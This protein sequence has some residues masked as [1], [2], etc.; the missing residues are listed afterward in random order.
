[1]RKIWHDEAWEEYK[2]WQSKDKK[3]LK[4]IN[5]LIESIDRNGYSSIG[6]PEA[7]RGNQAGFYSIRIDKKNRLIFRVADDAIE[8]AQCGGRYDDK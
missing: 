4:K 2:E 6:K 7:L 3:I 8:I 5:T 1:M